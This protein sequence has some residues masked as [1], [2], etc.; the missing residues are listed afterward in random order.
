MA[1]QNLTTWLGP[2]P[3]IPEYC[4]PLDKPDFSLPEDFA[5][6]FNMDPNKAVEQH[7]ANRDISFIAHVLFYCPGIYPSSL[8]KFVFSKENYSHTF[9]VHYFSS[10]TLDFL[11]ITQAVKFLLS[12]IA[13]PNRTS[14]IGIIFK[15]FADAYTIGNPSCGFSYSD[16]NRIAI[17]AILFSIRQRKDSSL[18]Q[19]DFEAFLA[20]TALDADFKVKFYNELKTQAVPIF[21]DFASSNCEPNYSKKGYLKK[22][23]GMFKLTGKKQRFFIID[24]FILKYFKDESMTQQMGEVELRDSVSTFVPPEK[25]DPEHLLIKRFDGGPIGAKVVKGVKKGGH[26][27]EYV[28]YGN[29][30]DLKSWVSAC[31]FVSFWSILDK[32]LQDLNKNT[33]Q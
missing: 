13:F 29:E 32:F 7:L 27:T 9:L 5:R 11:D 2:A 18:P 24:G 10:I 28:A 23:G 1:D 22:V 12:R 20:P 3:E 8:T 17:A 25:K 19:A 16:V 15:A 14:Y 31:N 26:H 30:E 33:A 4:I 21:F 6:E